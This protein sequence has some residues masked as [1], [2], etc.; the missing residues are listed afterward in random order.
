[1][2]ERKNKSE[3]SFMVLVLNIAVLF[4][5]MFKLVSPLS[6]LPI[7]LAAGNW[8]LEAK[9]GR[10]QKLGAVIDVSLVI[11]F[12]VLGFITFPD[13]NTTSF[14]FNSDIVYLANKSIPY[15]LFSVPSTV[16]ICILYLG[17]FISLCPVR[18][19]SEYE[20]KHISKLITNTDSLKLQTTEIKN[21]D[22][23]IIRK[24]N[25]I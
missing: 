10:M 24:N 12:F 4:T 5:T 3:I 8:V 2:K 21:G 18:R 15:F 19:K 17:D 23:V 7:A 1:M 11:I 22:D 25:N 14:V 16:L 6:L 13:A 20:A 9:P